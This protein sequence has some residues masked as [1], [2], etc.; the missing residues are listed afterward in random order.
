MHLVL[1]QVDML[2]QID[3]CGRPLFF[4]EQRK[5]RWVGGRGGEREELGGEEEGETDRDVK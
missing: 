2:R 3:I 5:E 4:R 1:L